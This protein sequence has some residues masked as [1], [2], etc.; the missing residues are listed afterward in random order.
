MRPMLISLCGG[1]I[2]LFAPWL[3]AANDFTVDRSQSH[4]GFTGMQAEEPFNGHF[5]DYTAQIRFSPD[6]LGASGVQL[7]VVMASVRVEGEER[8]EE[9]TG[10]E[11]LHVAAFTHAHFES[12]AIHHVKDT[13]YLAEGTLT[14]RGIR[15]PVR[16]PFT[17]TPTKTGYMAEGRFSIHRRDYSV[18]TGDWESDQWV[19]YPVEIA[20]RLALIAANNAP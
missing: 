11:W 17:L 14:I 10:S 13:R 5:P 8:Q 20:F 7:S 2:A 6:N 16:V 15:Q 18:G 9:I 19:A 3:A 12:T 1:V 4:I